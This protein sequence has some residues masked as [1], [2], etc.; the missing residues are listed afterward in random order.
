VFV[1]PRGRQNSPTVN[2]SF[3]ENNR[4]YV[5]Y[6][7]PPFAVSNGSAAVAAVRCRMAVSI[8]LLMNRT[9]PSHSAK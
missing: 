5:L 6:F 7:A 2:P 4:W 1:Q 3:R 9:L 8:L